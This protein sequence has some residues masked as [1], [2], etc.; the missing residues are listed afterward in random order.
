MR[1]NRNIALMFILSN[2]AMNIK[3]IGRLN[4]CK[5]V[6]RSNQM[7][8]DLNANACYFQNSFY[9]TSFIKKGYMEKSTLCD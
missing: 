4:K 5:G 6:I 3:L 7:T 8:C 2:D 1:A 9:D